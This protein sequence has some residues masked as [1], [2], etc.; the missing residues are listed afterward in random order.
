MRRNQATSIA[1]FIPIAGCGRRGREGRVGS[2]LAPKQPP[3]KV[4]FFLQMDANHAM[5][6]RIRQGSRFQQSSCHL[7]TLCALEVDTSPG[8]FLAGGR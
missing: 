1:D 8:V 5:A 6:G 2:G 7:L 4:P 3:V